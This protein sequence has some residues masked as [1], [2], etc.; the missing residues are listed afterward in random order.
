MY[1]PQNGDT[2]RVDRTTADGRSYSWIGVISRIDRTDRGIEG[3]R[4]TGTTSTGDAEDTFLAGAINLK[5]VGI[6]QTIRPAP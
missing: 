2:V 6:T 5:K 4:L 3:F 1:Q